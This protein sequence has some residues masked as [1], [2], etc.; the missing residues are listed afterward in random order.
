MCKE[1]VDVKITLQPAARASA[2]ADLKRRGFDP[3]IVGAFR[4]PDFHGIVDVQYAHGFYHVQASDTV[5]CSY[6]VVDI[7]R[8]KA[9][10]RKVYE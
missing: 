3:I 5:V 6:P 1:Y 10:S 2:Q 8:I 7:A 4:G 9:T